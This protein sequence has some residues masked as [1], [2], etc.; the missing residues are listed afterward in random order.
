MMKPRM[1][2]VQTKPMTPVEEVFA[3]IESC[4][5]KDKMRCRTASNV[6]EQLRRCGNPGVQEKD[7]DTLLVSGMEVWERE[8]YP[9][10]ASYLEWI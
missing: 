7:I 4:P 10:N 6:F 8:D 9:D 2:G 5:Q 3:L 1:R